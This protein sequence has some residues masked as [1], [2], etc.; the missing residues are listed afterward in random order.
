MLIWYIANDDHVCRLNG[1]MSSLH[2]AY[3]H[4][5]NSVRV[6]LYCMAW[7][8]PDCS[9]AN[10]Q[11]TI[12]FLVAVC[13]YTIKYTHIY[14]HIIYILLHIKYTQEKNDNCINFLCEFIRLYQKTGETQF[15]EL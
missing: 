11:D 5:S 1:I 10:H 12:Y 9:F 14:V 3:I 4:P 2:A 8:S 15:N 7:S 6:D 13:A